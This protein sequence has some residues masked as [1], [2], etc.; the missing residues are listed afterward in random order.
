MCK[1][2][3]GLHMHTIHPHTCTRVHPHTCTQVQPHTCTQ[4]TPTHAHMY[5][6]THAHKY[7]HTHAHTQ[8]KKY[9]SSMTNQLLFFFFVPPIRQLLFNNCTK[10]KGDQELLSARDNLGHI[11]TLTKICG[12]LWD[13]LGLG[14][15]GLKTS[16]GSCVF[17]E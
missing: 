16:R 12:K 15:G 4:V 13:V 6:H 17:E 8:R 10:Q 3:S 7:T 1:L 2:T 5:T 9:S 11:I 14:G